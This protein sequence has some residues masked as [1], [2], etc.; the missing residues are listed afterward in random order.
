MGYRV[1][2]PLPER[3]VWRRQAACLLVAAFSWYA[4]APLPWALS[5]FAHAAHQAAHEGNSVDVHED[6][7]AGHG[8]TASDIP[9]SPLHPE[10]HDCFDC[11]V[12]K[13]LAHCILPDAAVPTVPTFGAAPADRPRFASSP[14]AVCVVP[15]PPNRAP[16]VA[17]V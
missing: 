3:R 15:T 16:P 12:I 14:P 5:T 10:D 1:H 11:Q 13:Y 4:L 2:L 17:T 8:L 6:E 9:G 7:D